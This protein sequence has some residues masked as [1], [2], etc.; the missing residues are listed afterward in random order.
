MC[1]RGAGQSI[2]LDIGASVI[3]GRKIQID[4]SEA[5]ISCLTGGLNKAAKVA[6]AAGKA[7]KSGKANKGQRNSKEKGEKKRVHATFP[8]IFVAV[9]AGAG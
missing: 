1:L 8:G 7:G 4:W 6:K 2:A 3:S 5:G 9:R